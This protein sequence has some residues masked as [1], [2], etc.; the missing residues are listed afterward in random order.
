[1][2]NFSS[3]VS[4]ALISPLNSRLVY[5]V[6]YPKS[7]P[8]YLRDISNLIFPLISS[9]SPLQQPV[10]IV[11][12]LNIDGIIHSVDQKENIL[13][14]NLNLLLPLPPYPIHQQV[15][16]S[17]S[18]KDILNLS[19]CQHNVHEQIVPNHHHVSYGLL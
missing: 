2:L 15:S 9:S 5:S 17:L 13:K 16:F 1:M 10:P 8:G 14:P 3:F 4:L 7:L 11:P 6:A 19:T 12:V 18:S